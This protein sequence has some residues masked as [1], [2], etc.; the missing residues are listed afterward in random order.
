VLPR[1]DERGDEALIAPNA[2]IPKPITSEN[3]KPRFSRLP[4][5]SPASLKLLW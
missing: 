4:I 1:A 2:T 3:V 5:T